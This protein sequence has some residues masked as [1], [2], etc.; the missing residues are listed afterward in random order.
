MQPLLLVLLFAAAQNVKI[1][2]GAKKLPV[3]L[4]ANGTVA[5][6]VTF[7]DKDGSHA[8]YI[9]RAETRKGDLE[10][11]AFGYV[12]GSGWTKQWQATDFV[13]DCELDKVLDY[14]PKSFSVTD[15]DDDGVA[16]VTFAYELTCA[17]DV[18]PHTLKILMYEGTAK[19]A[20]RGETVV[21]VGGGQKV[22]GTHALDAA[23]KDAPPA[24]AKHLETRWTELTRQ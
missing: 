1:E 13:R 7:D 22:G 3:G 16:E 10:L 18:S 21:D 5:A 23:I 8:A 12:K 2:E 20:V 9:E 24:F 14:R 15:L 4:K 17:G 19:Y 11:R 6:L